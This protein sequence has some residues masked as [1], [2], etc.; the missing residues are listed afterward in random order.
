MARPEKL[1]PDELASF[2]ASHPEW[3]GDSS[4]IARTYTFPGYAEAVG[5]T[6]AVALVAE[7]KDHHPDI[8]LS[9]GKVEVRWSTHD[10]G[11]VTSLDAELA[12]AGDGLY[13]VKP[14]GVNA[15]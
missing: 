1:L 13:R 14:K 6:M 7:R 11:G 3:K 2:F 9:W 10:A 8:M 5:F 15:Q 4:S 12:D